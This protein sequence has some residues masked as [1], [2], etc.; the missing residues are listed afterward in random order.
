MPFGAI[1]E[2][3]MNYGRRKTDVGT[4]IK[5]IVI[6]LIIVVFMPEIIGVLEGLK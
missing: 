3:D 4:A 5:I 1:G 6:L 2:S